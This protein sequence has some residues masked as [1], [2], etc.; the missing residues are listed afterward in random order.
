MAPNKKD[1][2]YNELLAYLN[3]HKYVENSTEKYTHLSYGKVTGKYYISSLDIKDFIRLYINAVNHEVD[4]LSILEIQPEYGPIIVDID[5]KYPMEEGNSD[6]L[7]NDDMILNII[8]KYKTS[9]TKYLEITDIDNCLIFVFE[10]K[11]KSEKDDYYKDGFH[12]LFNEIV[13]NAA[14]RHLIRHDVVEMCKEEKLFD[15]FIE[16]TDKII[17]RAVVSSNGWFLPYSKKPSGYCYYLTK[18]YNYNLELIND[19]EDNNL[20]KDEIIKSCYLHYNFKKYKKKNANKI[21]VIYIFLLF[22]FSIP[23][24]KIQISSLY[25]VYFLNRAHNDYE[26]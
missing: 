1:K 10:K 24:L 6:R 20:S 26:Y 3:E 22:H 2:Y 7:Y 16:N 11:H 8:E 23:V 19:N 17:D 12:I 21:L 4:D 14:T 5:L 18:L 13:A 9:I 25:M 15:N